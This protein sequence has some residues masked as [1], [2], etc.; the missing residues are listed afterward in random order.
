MRHYRHVTGDAKAAR[1]QLATYRQAVIDREIGK[2]NL[3]M[4]GAILHRGGAQV[5]AG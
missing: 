2:S 4:P 3:T 5:A 1:H